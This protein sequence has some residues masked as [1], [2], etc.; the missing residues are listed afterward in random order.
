MPHANHSALIG[1]IGRQKPYFVV[2][3]SKAYSCP[4]G[5]RLFLGINDK[6]VANNSGRFS[7]TIK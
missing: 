7:A 2:G 3:T 6:D 5:G 4:G 1:S